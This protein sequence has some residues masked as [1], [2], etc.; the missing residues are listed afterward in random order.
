[1]GNVLRNAVTIYGNKY[2]AGLNSYMQIE[3]GY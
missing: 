1:V 3:D 2:A